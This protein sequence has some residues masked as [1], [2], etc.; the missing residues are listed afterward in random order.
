MKISPLNSH[1]ASPVTA[2]FDQRAGRWSETYYGPQGTL[3]PR[4]ERFRK[5][6]IALVPSGGA[7][8]DFGCGTGELAVGLARAGYRVVACDRSPNMIAKARE[9]HCAEDIEWTQVPPR[10]GGALLP[11]EEWRFDAV[12][13]SSVL[14]YLTALP[15]SL[16]E[17]SRVMKPGGWLMATVPNIVHLGRRHE[18]RRRWLMQW[19]VMRKLV[20]YSP[21]AAE[22]ELQW[23]SRNRLPIETW[24]T[25]VA[26]AGFAPVL[27]DC[28]FHTLS[29]LIGQ[30]AKP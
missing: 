14:E 20:A 6:V 3:V 16:A 24:A 22:F 15:E 27:Q 9:L 4:L 23:L 1:D 25:L 26:D 30:R 8:L 13:S 12:V 7:V 17:L 10:D 21:W 19:A 28:Q 18:P 29:L 5:Q 11:F 2:F